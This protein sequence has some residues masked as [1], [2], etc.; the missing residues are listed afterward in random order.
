MNIKLFARCTMAGLALAAFMTLGAGPGW[1]RQGL[2]IGVGAAQQSAAGDLD[3]TH[4]YADPAGSPVILAGK[5]DSGQAG[6]A[7]VI[8][9]GLSRFF[10]LEYLMATSQH[11]ASSP[12]TTLTSNASLT[13]QVLG[14]RLTLPFGDKV[15]VFVRGGYGAYELDYNAY[16][17]DQI[18]GTNNKVAFTGNGT[19]VG[20][21][22]ELFF[23]RLGVEFGYTTHNISFDRASPGGSQRLTLDPK[24]SASAATSDVIF[25]IHF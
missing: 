3:G 15:E 19:A 23:G 12:L 1:A 13:S 24:L 6:G 11:Q 4:S 22:I 10:A 7:A 20:G 2:Y 25:S 5:L 9:Y 21:G 14:A 8:G 17:F 18:T 16:S